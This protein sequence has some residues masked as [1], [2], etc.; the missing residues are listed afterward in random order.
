LFCFSELLSIKESPI[1][2][3]QHV[4][5]IDGRRKKKGKIFNYLESVTHN[6]IAAPSASYVTADREVR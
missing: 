5:K 2:I 6:N 4:E 1:I 3:R